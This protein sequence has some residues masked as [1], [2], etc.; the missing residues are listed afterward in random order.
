MIA[1]S[2]RGKAPGH[3]AVRLPRIRHFC[4]PG[5]LSG[6][7]HLSSETLQGPEE[8]NSSRRGASL[9][10]EAETKRRIRAH[11]ERRVKESIQGGNE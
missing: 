7:P 6:E 9:L 10:P 1:S 3:P 8:P 5:R 11:L 4:M 2:V